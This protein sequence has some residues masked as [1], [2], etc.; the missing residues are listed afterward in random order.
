MK[1]LNSYADNMIE[2]HVILDL[3]PTLASLY[4]SKKLGEECTL[5]AAQQAILL[6]LGLQRKPVDALEVNL[7]LFGQVY[8]G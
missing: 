5:S 1:R 7:F 8:S 6:A 3:V 2:Y 4:F